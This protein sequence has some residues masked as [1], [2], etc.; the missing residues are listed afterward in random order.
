MRERGK[1]RETLGPPLLPTLQGALFLGLG[2]HLFFFWTEASPP[3]PHHRVASRAVALASSLVSGAHRPPHL[4]ANDH[5]ACTGFLTNQ[6][7]VHQFFPFFWC[8]KVKW[9]SSQS[10]QQHARACTTAGLARAKPPRTVAHHL[11]ALLLGLPSLCNAQKRV[12]STANCAPPNRGCLST[13]TSSSVHQR[14]VA[15]PNQGLSPRCWWR[16]APPPDRSWPT[17]SLTPIP[18]CREPLRA[19]A[20]LRVRRPQCRI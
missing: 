10:T 6:F 15:V 16:L 1:K 18:F 9:S 12:V 4:H 20:A 5:Q 19:H 8:K 11:A 7:G 14:H 13:T 17:L 2:H 3:P